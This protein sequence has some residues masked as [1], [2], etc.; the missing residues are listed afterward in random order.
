MCKFLLTFC[1]CLPDAYLLSLKDLV[2]PHLQVCP[3]L[4]LLIQLSDCATYLFRDRND[5]SIHLG[6]GIML[7]FEGCVLNL[8]LKRQTNY[9]DLN[10]QG[11]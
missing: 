1:S 7:E 11:V 2:H 6:L 10:M 8:E 9:V 5:Q 4:W 3:Y